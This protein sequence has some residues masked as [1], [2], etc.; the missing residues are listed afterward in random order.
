[1]SEVS[2][3]ATVTDIGKILQKK[4]FRT[5]FGLSMSRESTQPQIEMS[6]RVISWG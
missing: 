6:T 4:H 5:S 1:M 2:S 3:K